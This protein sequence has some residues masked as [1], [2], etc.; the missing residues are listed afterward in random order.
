MGSSA[1]FSPCRTWRYSLYRPI[2]DMLGHGSICFVLLNPSTADETR[3][4]QTIKRCRGY[5]QA[6]GYRA[7]NVVNLFAIRAT[8]PAVMKVAADPIGPENDDTIREVA[9]NANAVVVAWGVHG[10]HRGRDVQVLALLRAISVAPLWLGV[11]RGGHP[12]HPLYQPA[13]LAP[14]VFE[15]LAGVAS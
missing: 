9:A 3:D 2:G 5:A 8:D 12:K 7:L 14:V 11:T 13:G 6:W 1:V 4:D 15:S 10:G